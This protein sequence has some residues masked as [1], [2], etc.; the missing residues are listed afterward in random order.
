MY[1]IILIT[2]FTASGKDTIKDC[3][4]KDGGKHIV[5]TTTRPMRTG[6]RNKEDY[7]FVSDGEFL[8]MIHSNEMIEHRVYKTNYQNKKMD[9]YY[10]TEFKELSKSQTNVIVVDF[11]GVE[12][13]NQI[14]NFDITT[15]HLKCS[16][17]IRRERCIN[18]GDYDVTEFNRRLEDDKKKF[19]DSKFVDVVIDANQSPEEI[20]EILKGEINV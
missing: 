2:G 4:V 5:P 8:N 14:E 10:G 12:S 6:E 7:N 16:E 18:R 11:Q 3:F 9:W 13:F 20:Y 15:I 19:L 17:D 1:K